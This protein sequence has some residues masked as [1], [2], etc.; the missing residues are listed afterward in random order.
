MH[1]IEIRHLEGTVNYLAQLIASSKL[2]I[3]A[4]ITCSI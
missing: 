1:D 2:N 4:T 3:H